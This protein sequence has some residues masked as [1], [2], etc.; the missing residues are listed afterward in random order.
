MSKSYSFAISGPSY[1]NTVWSTIVLASSIHVVRLSVCLSVSLS[2]PLF[3]VALR[4][5]L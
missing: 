2:V 3:T 4:V 1:C 5:G